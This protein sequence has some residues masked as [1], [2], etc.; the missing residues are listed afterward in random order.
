MVHP[1]LR[2]RQGQ[3]HVE[4]PH[5]KLERVLAKTYG[6]PIFQEQVMKL[7]IAV[8]DY[9]PGEADQLRRDMGA[10]RSSGRIEQHRERL[11][12]RMVANGIDAEFAER[13][14]QQ[15]P[16]IRR[17]RVPREPRGLVRVDRLCDG[18]AAHAPA[19][20]V[21][22]CAAQRAAD[23]LL[24][25]RDLGRGR[26]STRDRGPA[27]RR[28]RERVGLHARATHDRGWRRRPGP[29]RPLGDPHGA[30][31]D[32]GLSCGRR[33]PVVGRSG[34][35]QKTRVWSRSRRAGAQHGARSEVAATARRGRCTRALRSLSAAARRH[36]Q[37]PTRRRLGGAGRDSLAPTTACRCAP[38]PAPTS[39][40]SRGS[41]TAKQSAG[42]IEPRTTA[43][44][45][46]RSNCYE[47][48]CVHAGCPTPRRSAV[49]PTGGRS[50][51][52][53]W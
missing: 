17:V 9:S 29:A 48:I 8:A 18:V 36:D 21:L 11:V 39:P 40:R 37:H 1:Y 15:I 30:A 52:S 25:G 13:V 5:P 14:F 10:W 19:T 51:T 23:G 47:T 45:G 50:V 2:R 32:Q 38:T 49:C 6:V 43:R 7:A 35:R 16:R 33:R 27:D 46:I 53:G 24:L 4:Y 3:E 31:V 42:T 41:D 20:G 28:G 26:A 12:S 22:V 44:A 34:A